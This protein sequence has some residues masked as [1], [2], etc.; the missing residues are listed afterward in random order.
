MARRLGG[1]VS[2]AASPGGEVGHA[3]SVDGSVV[4]R[5]TVRA[6]QERLDEQVVRGEV[7]DQETL[8]GME[9]KRRAEER[10]SQV[11]P[12]TNMTLRHTH[13]DRAR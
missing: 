8:A 2:L 11:K 7:P 13:V 6:A 9:E 12:P 5:E 1:A 3:G 10:A 4:R